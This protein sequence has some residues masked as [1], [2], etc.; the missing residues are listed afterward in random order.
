LPCAFIIYD[1]KNYQF[2]VEIGFQ[3]P[4]N[5]ELYIKDL[6]PIILWIAFLNTV[7]SIVLCIGKKRGKNFSANQ[8][9][10]SP[11]RAP[12]VVLACVVMIVS[13]VK[14]VSTL[15]AFAAPS[16]S[17]GNFTSYA[18]ILVSD[19]VFLV[20]FSLWVYTYSDKQ[21]VQFLFIG[22]VGALSI[23]DVLFCGS[24]GSII[25][26]FNYCYLVPIAFMTRM[27][28]NLIPFPR[29][30]IFVA[31]LIAAFWIFSFSKEYRN[32][33]FDKDATI[34]NKIE[35][36]YYI[37][38][39]RDY[40]D[41]ENLS[42][43]FTKAL[44][45]QSADF[46]RAC[47]ITSS[48][49]LNDPGSQRLNLFTYFMKNTVNQLLPGTPFPSAFNP[50]SNILEKII[51]IENLEDTGSKE[52]M[53]GTNTQPLTLI[54]IMTMFAGYF[55]F[56]P[57][58]IVTYLINNLVERTEKPVL[59]LVG[60]IFYNI[61]LHGYGIEIVLKEGVIYLASLIFFILCLKA[62]KKAYK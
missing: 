16:E 8:L 3:I 12:F 49:L 36:T 40:R 53:L 38:K 29:L 59:G 7:S 56:V 51:F 19:T 62:M 33:L 46:D 31:T 6:F 28:D 37:N 54:G 47:I 14:S 13:Y 25:K 2:G 48:F 61:L 1:I 39:M 5:N 30:I 34:I 4:F 26:I 45:R 18:T 42:T 10:S 24:K 50:T 44:I 43:M 9:I 17:N 41:R 57:L 21:K 60:L 27:K 22:I 58:S 11:K 55:A 32:Q 15:Q 23:F 52:E 20:L 35:N